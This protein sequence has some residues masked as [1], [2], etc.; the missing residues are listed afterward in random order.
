MSS[1]VQR[2]AEQNKKRCQRSY[3]GKGKHRTKQ[4]DR[5]TKKREG[6]LR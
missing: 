4:C 6:S 5:E 1:T 2:V 3:E